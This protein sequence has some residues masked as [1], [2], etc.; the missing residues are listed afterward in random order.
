MGKR[1]NKMQ[2]NPTNSC[3]KIIKVGFSWKRCGRKFDEMKGHPCR[4]YNNDGNW[5]GRWLCDHCYDKDYRRFNPNSTTNIKK[6]CANKR[7]GNMKMD[8][9]R[10]KGDLYEAVTCKIRRVDNI[11]ILNDNY[12]SPIDHS[13]DFELGIIQTKGKLYD[14]IYKRWVQNCER[15]LYKVF[16]NLIFYCLSK[17]G[18]IIERVYII[19]RHEVAN[20]I[21]IGIYDNNKPHWYDIYRVDERPYNDAYQDLLRYLSNKKYFSIEDINKWLKMVR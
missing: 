18:K 21:N 2:Y 6:S 7:S 8:N 3:D 19:P 4:E 11:N 15:E 17:D 16:D 20:R 9:N 1:S 10:S 12:S 14:N 5:T 13:R